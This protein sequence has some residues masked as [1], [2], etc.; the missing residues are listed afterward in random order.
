MPLI[1]D[2]LIDVSGRPI[3]P[4]LLQAKLRGSSRGLVEVVAGSLRPGDRL[5]LLVDQFEELFRY[6]GAATSPE[7][8]E[9]A[10]SFVH[11]LWQ[12]SR[13]AEIPIYIILTMRAEFLG[14]CPEFADLNEAVN[15]G[16]YLVPRFSRAQLRQTIERPVSNRISSRLVNRLLNE[17]GDDQDQLPILQHA[18]MRLWEAW[19]RTAEEEIDLKHYE[20][21]GDLKAALGNHLD[22]I[23]DELGPSDSQD[24]RIAQ[25]VFCR[26]TAVSADGSLLRQPASLNDLVAAAHAPVDEIRKV[27][28]H[29]RRQGR[30]FLVLTDV[31]LSE[32]SV[33]EISHESLIRK[34]SRLVKWMQPQIEARKMHDYLTNAAL[35]WKQH[36]RAKDDLLAGTRLELAE[37]WSKSHDSRLS[38][39]EHEF[40]TASLKNPQ[41]FEIIANWMPVPVAISSRATNKI[42]LANEPFLRMFGLETLDEIPER[43]FHHFYFD[44]EDRAASAAGHGKAGLHRR[45][46][47]PISTKKWRNVLG[48]WILAV[49]PVSR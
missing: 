7:R 3:P 34:W 25:A 37:E 22:E 45:P 20:V 2:V 12:G 44:P 11:L 33:I 42:M 16:L 38:S 4:E 46:H 17:L 26:L 47:R 43:R 21:V 14:R 29:F 9:E 10:Q 23:L 30:S 13:D 31:P 15:E 32:K 24:A 8:K 40:L 48:S 19:A 18:L 35:W 41:Q 1:R 39:L 6:F 28:E 49:N 27:V 5:V 36:D